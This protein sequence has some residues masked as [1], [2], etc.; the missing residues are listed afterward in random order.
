MGSL[1]VCWGLDIAWVRNQVRQTCRQ[2]SCE[3][4]SRTRCWTLQHKISMQKPAYI[5]S[6][7]WLKMVSLLGQPSYLWVLLVGQLI[8]PDFLYNRYLEDT[9]GTSPQFATPKLSEHTSAQNSGQQTSIM[10][11]FF[12]SRVITRSD[13]KTRCLGDNMFFLITELF[14]CD[15]LLNVKV[16]YLNMDP[17]TVSINRR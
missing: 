16:K 6:L 7:S 15:L 3:S 1:N 13:L 17:N 11:N 8:W 12:F 9:H 10:V 4:H 2:N 5:K 14:W